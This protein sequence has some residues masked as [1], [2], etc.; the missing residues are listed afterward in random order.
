[1][2]TKFSVNTIQHLVPLQT[3]LSLSFLLS[4][5]ISVSLYQ[6]VFYNRLWFLVNNKQISVPSHGACAYSVVFSSSLNAHLMNHSTRLHHIHQRGNVHAT[7]QSIQR[8][9][10]CI[11]KFFGRII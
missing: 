8:L 4:Y 7:Q 11:K 10:E 6:G 1:M 3:H 5:S 2:H 9:Y